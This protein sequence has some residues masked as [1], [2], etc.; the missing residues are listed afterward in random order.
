MPCCPQ[1]TRAIGAIR[2]NHALERATLHLLAREGLRARLVAHSDWGGFTLYGEIETSRVRRAAAEALA[3][4]RAGE[5]DLALHAR[6][7]ARYAVRLL[8]VGISLA[9]AAR[10]ARRRPGL[11]LWLALLGLAAAWVLGYPLGEALQ[12]RWTASPDPGEVTLRVARAQR[13]GRLLWHR[14]EIAPGG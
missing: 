5:A 14:V 7:G 4:L 12:R 8:G 1:V 3:R 13:L 10:L 11:A 9:A 6:C 2:R